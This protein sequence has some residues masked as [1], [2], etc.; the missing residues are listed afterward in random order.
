[1]WDYSQ[2]SLVTLVVTLHT[3]ISHFWPACCIMEEDTATGDNAPDSG[4]GDGA[5]QPGAGGGG[6][7]AVVAGL[8]ANLQPGVSGDA[9]LERF[10][11]P[12][13][14][15]DKFM[16]FKS[17]DFAKRTVLYKCRLCQPKTTTVSAHITSLANLKSHMKRVHLK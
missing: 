16:E 11:N 6:E 13:P 15:L 3:L 12:W 14:H 2:F 17:A 8:E 7:Q 4:A 1:M 5:E 10:A 9:V